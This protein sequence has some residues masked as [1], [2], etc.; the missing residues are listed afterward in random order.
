VGVW[1]KREFIID[2]AAKRHRIHKNNNLH[3]GISNSYGRQKY[4]FGFF[5]RPS[6]LIMWNFIS[7]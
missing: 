3:I 2:I 6:K 5:A 7:S 4:E 1:V